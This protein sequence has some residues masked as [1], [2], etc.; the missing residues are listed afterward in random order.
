MTYTARSSQAR[1]LIILMN[2][3]STY[4]QEYCGLDYV[5]YAPGMSSFLRFPQ[6][7]RPQNEMKKKIMKDL[8]AQCFYSR[9]YPGAS[10]V[11]KIPQH[12]KFHY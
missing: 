6:S 1:H 8:F 9:D 4:P 10:L 12:K 3:I 2:V 11:S 7:E 5:E